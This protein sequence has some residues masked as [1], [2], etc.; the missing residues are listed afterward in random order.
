[1]GLHMN[2]VIYACCTRPVLN[3]VLNNAPNSD[4]G[5]TDLYVMLC[6]C[7]INFHDIMLRGGHSNDEQE[8]RL[9]PGHYCVQSK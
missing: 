5:C 7:T 8:I 2:P 4:E 3:G 6:S 9:V 1:M